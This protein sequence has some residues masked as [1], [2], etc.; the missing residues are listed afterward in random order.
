MLLPLARSGKAA[1]PG[2]GGRP[3]QRGGRSLLA[4]SHAAARRGAA[5]RLPPACGGVAASIFQVPPTPKG[6]VRLAALLAVRAVLAAAT[7]AR[8]SLSCGGAAL[9]P[10]VGGAKTSNMK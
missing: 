2:A 7:A 9:R 4:G 10:P 8:F 5:A 1:S 3:G 6:A